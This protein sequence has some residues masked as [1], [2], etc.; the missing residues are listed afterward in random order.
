M[1]TLDIHACYM[2]AGGLRN[3][4]NAMQ[5]IFETIKVDLRVHFFD[6]HAYNMH[7]CVHTGYA[8]QWTFETIKA[9]SLF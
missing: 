1:F 9:C 8:M 5:W 2:H 4:S 3:S 6:M 7:A